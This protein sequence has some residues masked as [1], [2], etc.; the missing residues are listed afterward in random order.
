[1]KAVDLN[2][3]DRLPGRRLAPEDTFR[4]RCHPDIECFNRC[5]RNLNLY[6]YPYD[7]LRLKNGLKINSDQFLE[8]HVDVVLRPGNHFPEVLLK[9][10][11]NEERTCP[12]L[13]PEG[14]RVYPDRPGTCRTFP[15]EQGQLF[16]DQG[17]PGAMLYFL[18]PPEFCLGPRESRQWTLNAWFRDQNAEKYNGHTAKWA[19]FKG[20]FHADSGR[21]D[22]WRGQ[23]PDSSQG[24][25]AFMAV[26][27]LDRFREFVFES[28]FR[29][30]YRIPGPTLKKIKRDDSEL[31]KF[32]YQWVRLYLFGISTKVI[33]PFK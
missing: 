9:M 30:R 18:R 12:F 16:D 27:N 6:L 26:Y 19:A 14:C 28:S 8:R 31:L 24:K 15:V 33:R 3:L 21:P 13:S 10:A 1:M 29:R 25:M 5:C 17:R 32:G 20:L 2:D 11:D 4:F 7:V 23:G 22:P